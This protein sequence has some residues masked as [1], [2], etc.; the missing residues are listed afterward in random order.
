MGAQAVKNIAGPVRVYRVRTEPAVAAPPAVQRPPSAARSRRRD[1][2][3]AAALLALLGGGVS[4][5][6]LVSRP[7]SP[8]PAK[9]SIAVLPFVNMSG[10][11]EQE[12]FSDGMTEDLITDLSRLTGLLVTA[13]S[14]VFTTKGKAVKPD[15]VSREF[16]VRY[17]IEGSVRKANDQVRITAQLVDATTGY[18]LW[19]QRYDRD[20]QDIFAVQ[21]DIARRITKALAVQLTGEEEKQIG[22][23]YTSSRV[24]WEYFMRGAE[25]YRR[26]TPKDNARARELF[27]KAIDLDPEFA[28]A[29]A[30]LAATQR[31]DWILRWTQDP[32]TSKVLAYR[33]VQK[34]VELAR[35]E[36]NPKPSLPY[37]LEQLAY[38]LT[39]RR[40]YQ[41]AIKAA[42]EAVEVDPRYADGYTVWAHVLIYLGKPEEARSK[43]E[44]AIELNTTP[45]NYP[46][47]YDYHLGQ[48]YYVW[49]FQTT[50]RRYYEKAEGYLQEALKKNKNSRPART[51]LVVVLWELDRKDD[52]AKQMAILREMRRPLARDIGGPEAFREYVQQAHPYEDPGITNHLS[53]RWLDAEDRLLQDPNLTPKP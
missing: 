15:Q 45:T 17:I 47:F 7:L 52:A 51:Y 36:L 42:E 1:A 10:D 31:Q 24:A 28:R 23:P 2:V 8:M 46:F 3:V 26:Y 21:D 35:R 19:A 30:S 39:Y 16:G 44:K 38:V 9:L 12:Y 29:Y 40:D 20:L 34:A 53:Q 27:E 32:E 6:H 18:H 25:L 50:E 13:R 37:T 49:G 48:A 4:V 33:M 41:G 5:W 22:R 14:S 43:T 11:P